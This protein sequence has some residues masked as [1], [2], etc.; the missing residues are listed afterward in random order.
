MSDPVVAKNSKRMEGDLPADLAFAWLHDHPEA[1]ALFFSSGYRND[2]LKSMGALHPEMLPL[3]ESMNM[4]SGVDRSTLTLASRTFRK[5]QMEILGILGLYALPYCYAGANG[6][7]VLV[8][9]RKI[10]EDPQQRLLETASFVLAVCQPDAFLPEGTGQMT[11]LNVRMMHAAARYYAGKVI[12]DEV[13]VN[14]EDMIGTL[15]SFSLLVVRGLRKIGIA[16]SE[17]EAEAYLY[18]WSLVGRMM[19][20]HP[21]YLPANLR[22][23]SAMDRDIRRREFRRSN[24]GIVLTRSLVD[25]YRKTMVFRGV[26][27]EDLLTFF[28]GTEIA[29][30]LDL[31][32]ST[33]LSGSIGF[34]FRM[35]QLLKDFGMVNSGIENRLYRDL[36]K[37]RVELQFKG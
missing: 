24:E 1:K 2:Q 26:G 31:T 23:A 35:Q 18:L 9:S 5:Y 17:R 11:I 27:P 30:M 15:L 7:R 29:Q 16:L 34:G 37:A 32:S 8:R 4:P 25:Y 12:A 13:P 20:I 28:L 21:I 3:L 19:G 22:A 6:A 14:Q 36:K 10:M 33:H